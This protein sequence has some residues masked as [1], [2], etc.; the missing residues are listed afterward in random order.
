MNKDQLLLELQNREIKCD[1]NQAD[2]MIKFMRF[3]LSWN[4]KINLTAIT[5]EESFMEKM[6]F[7]SAI[8][9]SELDLTE[10]SVLDVGTGAGFPGVILY[11]LNPKAHITL[12]DSTSKK[13]NLLK[14]YAASNNYS[15]DAISVRAEEYARN[16]REKYD[17]VFARAVAPLN[18]LLELCI[19][20][21]KVGGTFV[22]LKGPGAEDEI[23]DSKKAFSKLNAR[24]GKI[25][26][27]ELPESGEVRNII[28]I[29][30]DK[31]TSEKYPRE[32]KEIKRLPL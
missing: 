17:Y 12:L 27:D 19:P 6:I 31:K 22:V 30:K 20:L 5:D 8:G 7:D 28:H 11:L 15:Y 25:I 18:I 32:Y 24:I 26:V 2:E 3:V 16:H 10:K 4:E 29:I 13:I 14:E 1:E 9:I 21:L 23:I